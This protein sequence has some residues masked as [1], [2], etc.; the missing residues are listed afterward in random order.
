VLF[1]NHEN[2]HIGPFIEFL[3]QA[4]HVKSLNRDQWNLFYEFS[5]TMDDKFTEYDSS[6]AWP[7][8]FDEYVEWRREQPG[9]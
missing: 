3:K 6:A 4:S 9:Y 1:T 7:G 5:T 2:R 8:L